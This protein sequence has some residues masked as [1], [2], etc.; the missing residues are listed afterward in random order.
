MIHGLN[1]QLIIKRY[2]MPVTFRKAGKTVRAKQFC[3]TIAI[4]F[5]LFLFCT[6]LFAQPVG[7][8]MTNPIIMGTYAGGTYTYSDT[9]N[10]RVTFGYGDD[11]G[12]PS[13]DIY[14]QFT[15]QGT[16][17]VDISHCSSTFDT[18][19]WLLDA[20]GNIMASNN[21]N[22]TLCPSSTAASLRIASLPA[23]TYYIVSEGFSTNF[24]NIVTA[25]TLTVAMPPP[26]PGGWNPAYKIAPVNGI[27]NYSY[28]Q[29]PAQLVEIYAPAFVTTGLSYEWQESTSPIFSTYSVVGGS[30]TYN[31][32]TFLTQTKYYRRKTSYT[33]GAYIYSNTVKITVGSV[34]WE[35]INYI[36]EHDVLTTAITTFQGVD[37][38]AIGSKLQTTTYLDGLGRSVEKVSRETAVPSSGT[39][40][41]DIVQFSQYD[42]YG[43]QQTNYLPYT[44]T[45]Q[46][47]KYK[48]APVTDEAAYYVNPVTYNETSAFSSITFDNSP[49]NRVNNVKESGTAW[50][51]S[52]G[53]SAVYDMNDAA[54][55]VKIFDVD[56]IQGNPPVYKGAYPANY[57][58]KITYT[59]VNGKKVIEYTNKSGQLI[60]KKIQ[61][62]DIPTAAHTGWICT[63]N[64]YDD[65]GLLRYQIQPEG[66]KYLDANAWS[67]AGAN[68]TTILN[69]QCFQYNYDDKGRTIWKKAPG[70][71]PLRMLYDKRDRVVFMQDGNQAA[72]SPAQWTANIYDELDR[73]VISTL[74]N[75][76]STQTTL[77]SDIDNAVNTTSV[78]ITNNG[79]AP[80]VT[81]VLSLCPITSTNLNSS[82]VTTTLK[83]S[84]YD[85]YSFSAVKTFNTSFTNTTAYSTSDPNV[86]PIA[87]SVRTTNFVTGSMTRVLGTTTF[88]TSTEYYDEKG[89]HI[90]TLEDNLKTGVDIT[91][92]QYHFDGRLLSTC[93]DHTTTGTG[94]TNFKT[95]TKYVFDVIGRVTSIQKQ[96]GSNAMKTMA[97]YDYDDV[98]RLKT[99]HLEPGYTNPTNGLTEMES[100]GYSYNIHN[101]ITGINKDY[102]LKTP[103]N[104]NKWNHFFGLYLG[105][106]NRDNVFTKAELNGQVTGLQWNTMGDDNQRR[107]DYTYDNAG[108]LTSAL[109]K[110]QPHLGDGWSN[111]K[112]DFSVSGGVSGKMSYD[113]NG[114]LIEML[115]KGVVPGTSAPITI[116]DLRY[117]Y[118]TYS[119]QLSYV[120]DVMTSTSVNG[121]FADFKD[122]ANAAGTADYVYDANGNLVIDLNKNA[123]DLA[124]VVGAN[125]IKYNF[126]D[127]PEQ[128][129]IAGKGTIKIVYSA[130]GEKLQRV[131]IPETAGSSTITTYINEF[132]Y[133]ETS[134]TLTQASNPPFAGTGLALS[135]INFEEGRIRVITTT[136]Q[137]NTYGDLL[138][139]NGS[140]TLP[141][142]KMGVLDYFIMDYQQN[143]RMI[144]T[145][146]ARAAQNVAS[147]E[148]TRASVEDPIFGQTGAANEVETTRFNKPAGWTGNSTIS[149]SRL[150]NIAGKNIGPNTLQKVM[151][152]DVVNATVKYYYQSATGGDNPNIVNNLL[153]SL[154][155]N[156]NTSNATNSLVKGGSSGINTQLGGTTGFVNAVKPT[157]SGGTTPLAFLTILFFDERFN[158]ISAADGGVYQQQVASSVTGTGASLTPATN[159]KAP[160]NGYVYVYVSNRS[161]QDVYFDDLKVKIDAGNI[162]EENHYYAYGLKIAAISSKKIPDTYDGQ[163]KNNNLYNDKELWDDADLNWF[164]YGFRNYDPQI[165]RFTQLDPLT[166]DYPMLTPYQ[167]ASDEP[168]TNIDIDGLEA[169]TA[170]GGAARDFSYAYNAGESFMNFIPKAWNITRVASVTTSA[171]STTSRG[172][173]I[174]ASIT[175]IFISVANATANII[176]NGTFT[177]Q[178]GQNGDD[179]IKKLLDYGKSKSKRF[180]EILQ[181]SGITDDNYKNLISYGSRTGTNP[182]GAITIRKSNRKRELAGL[183]HE[184]TNIAKTPEFNK[185]RDKVKNG[186]ITPAKYAKEVL[187]SEI[188]SLLNQIVVYHDLKIRF[189]E[190]EEAGM[191]VLLGR[192]NSG[193]SEKR[194]LQEL[195]KDYKTLKVSDTGENAYEN[196]KKQGQMLRE[197]QI[198]LEKEIDEEIRKGLDST[199]HN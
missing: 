54:D 83:Y 74:Y 125:G 66:V 64:V 190:K 17:S 9:K 18:Y 69:E 117:T 183:A 167:Y 20:S 173:G 73:P 166:D 92:S 152:G 29:T 80:S 191:N 109:F 126:L 14:Y 149:V 154:I 24:G 101:Q 36:R 13:D 30:S 56:Y 38:L 153:S 28:N 132:V 172:L 108:R 58:Y 3:L 150:G 61:I 11:M 35:D 10:N 7:S 198:K 178:A 57:L 79:T 1:N 95:L 52:S 187:Y 124:G 165:G 106:D 134:T 45:N 151:A 138:T 130:D 25:V 176:N 81:A 171:L 85:N 162:I 63:Y 155:G 2:F 116:D 70:A 143:V 82:T 103:A 33:N 77:Q 93:G 34:N 23:G 141:N 91:T 156:L 84:F 140:L 8:N 62:N 168:I 5:F 107:Y 22:G 88:L 145:D 113:L 147:M 41:G 51:A 100:L 196:Y 144:L 76:A 48:T 119:N 86:M 180:S 4:L 136:S 189:S 192:Y 49:L 164:D 27:Y 182:A 15:I 121:Q 31:F 87:K 111:A 163:I 181:A 194:L 12:Q 133:Q 120:T 127:K 72:L 99:K 47:G 43:R 40:W 123:K 42:A 199:I 6:D 131:F 19:M 129:R 170:V 160:K 50:A 59:D 161:D 55:D 44:T 104:Y 142:S 157:G 174:A 60:L 185:L 39:L 21:N 94:Y 139:V 26:P 122:G 37:Q 179:P 135:F 148:T 32:P 137:S 53:N 97:T 115:Q 102:A 159:M 114:N 90:Q 46:S 110:E 71:S 67:F 188:Q 169:G 186:K 65:F 112:I 16:A 96:Y 98:G 78:T 177:P 105:Y 146:E 118:K 75:T 158:F 184:L 68:G 128:I 193:V 195:K 89:R 175:G 197:D